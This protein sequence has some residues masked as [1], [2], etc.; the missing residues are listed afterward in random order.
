MDINTITQFFTGSNLLTVF[1]KL[2]SIVVSFIY[3]LYAVIVTRQIRIMNETLRT[4]ADIVLTT[5]AYIQLL[6]AV[7]SIL[8]AIFVL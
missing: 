2:F 6:F 3:L 7:L 5:I 8:L 4:K 1:F